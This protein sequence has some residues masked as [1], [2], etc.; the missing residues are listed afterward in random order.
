LRVDWHRAGLDCY[1]GKETGQFDLGPTIAITATVTT[2]IW[3]V[4]ASPLIST[5]HPILSWGLTQKAMKAAVKTRARAGVDQMRI[6]SSA[7]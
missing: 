4:I 7:E 6:F 3:A 5:Q 1:H 2:L